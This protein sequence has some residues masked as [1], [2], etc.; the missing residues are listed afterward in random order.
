[1]PPSVGAAPRRRRPVAYN[2]LLFEVATG[3]ELLQVVSRLERRA[4][5]V[6]PGEMEE[7]FPVKLQP[8]PHA[9]EGREP[10]RAALVQLDAGPYTVLFWG[11]RSKMLMLQVAPTLD[12]TE[13]GARYCRRC[14]CRR[15]G[16]GGAAATRT[17]RGACGV[18]GG[19]LV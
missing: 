6:L 8:V 18:C 19:E 17:T 11:E 1:M 7:W 10:C 16:S 14:R 15:S 5:L 12:P 13:F 4:A 9:Y 2:G 3:L